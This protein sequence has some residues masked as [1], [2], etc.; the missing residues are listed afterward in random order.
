MGIDTEQWRARIGT[1]NGG[2]RCRTPSGSYQRLPVSH[3]VTWTTR[4]I[5]Q[6]TPLP[7]QAGIALVSLWM[8]LC[9]LHC[10]W[11]K[12]ESSQSTKIVQGCSF[13][14]KKDT[15]FITVCVSLLAAATVIFHSL[16]F[17]LIMA[18][19]VELNPGPEM[20]AFGLCT[21]LTCKLLWGKPEQACN[22]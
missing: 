12:I 1:Y 5:I 18:G 11:K 2:R 22:C 8:V 21:I 13:Y 20:G 6:T 17:L 14:R 7:V 4:D 15:M 16:A 9:S 10:L 19:D 3:A